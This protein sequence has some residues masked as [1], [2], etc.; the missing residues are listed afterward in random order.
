MTATRIL[1]IA[2]AQEWFALPYVLGKGRL[3]GKDGK[4]RSCLP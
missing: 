1:S 2:R 4:D 3:E